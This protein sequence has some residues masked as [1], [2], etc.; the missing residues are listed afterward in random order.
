MDD[1]S[2]TGP[3]PTGT[4]SLLLELPFEIREIIFDLT[5]S[6]E[7]PIV[8]F[9]LDHYQRESYQEAIQPSLCRVSRQVRE[10]SLPIF[11]KSHT[12]IFHTEDSKLNDTRRWL[13]CSEA[14]LPGLLQV[15]LWIRYVTLTNDPGTNG[16]LCVS[17]RRRKTDRVWQVDNSWKWVTV[18][19]KPCTIE[20]DARFLIATLNAI[21]TDDP[22]CLENAETFMNMMTDLRMLYIKEKM[23]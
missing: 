4:R 16:A 5:V 22:A 14:W 18:T 20:S 19:R 13:E 7:K 21:L 23:S 9:R 17:L 11:F 6:S 15:S 10:E 12:F 8:A 2:G 1:G 3:V